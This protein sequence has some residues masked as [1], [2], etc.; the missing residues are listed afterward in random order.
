M[1]TD[2]S[3]PLPDK[4]TLILEAA[5]AVFNERGYAAATMDEIAAAAGVA[6]GSLY[7]YFGG[8]QDLFHALFAHIV[9]SG[10]E[11]AGKEASQPVRASEKL[12]QLLD[13]WHRQLAF[14]R[15]FGRLVLE[16]WAVASRQEPDS[17]FVRDLAG[18]FTRGRE[19]FEDLIREGVTEGAFREDLDPAMAGALVKAMLDGLLLRS[20]LGVEPVDEPTMA[21]IKQSVY[22]SLRAAGEQEENPDA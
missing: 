10:F 11:Q 9:S 1:V 3:A 12:E 21:A 2:E 15:D 18:T 17:Q 14:Y 6:K 16:F 22:L 8:K 4:P 20:I 7:N 5:T 13:L 19:V